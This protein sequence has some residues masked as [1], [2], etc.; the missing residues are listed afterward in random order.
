MNSGGS[1][2]DELPSL[3]L[4]LTNCTESE[5]DALMAQTARSIIA[6]LDTWRTENQRIEAIFANLKRRR[7]T[8]T[9][10]SANMINGC[11]VEPNSKAVLAFSPC[12]AMVHSTATS[13]SAIL[14]PSSGAWPAH[15]NAHQAIRRNPGG[16]P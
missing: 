16:T 11:Q 15:A 10:S 1:K 2:S 7:T 8:K 6:R 5:W 13:S 14:S 3:L 12:I 4:S 9:T